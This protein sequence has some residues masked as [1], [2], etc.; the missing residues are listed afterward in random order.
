MEAMVEGQL[1]AYDEAGEGTPLVLIHGYPLTRRLW[2]PQLRELAA[3]ARVIALD[4]WGFGGSAAVGE[5]TMG[6]Y[7]DQVR[8]L[9]DELSIGRA[10]VGGL[11]M[12]GYITFEFFRRYSNR[13]A[14]L[15]FANT[16]AGPDS[17]EARAGRDQ[18]AELAR[19][20]G[21][22]AIAAAMLPKLLSPGAYA[23]NRGVVLTAEGIMRGSTVEGIVA[24][25]GAMRDRPDSTPTLQ[26]IDRPTLVIGGKD[27]QLIP[28]AESEKIAGGVRGGRLEM[29]PDAG[30]LSNLE[31]ADLFSRAV[32]DFL[33]KVG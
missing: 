7:A 16:K 19:E 25:L 10:V 18:S 3:H 6:T 23:G 12:G 30:H 5:A 13:V 22:D 24:A 27:D 14:G 32:G 2:E 8:A 31:Q 33:K 15:I 29:L 17:A 20:K 26:W 9:M 1:V 11:S 4:L 21:V 28:P